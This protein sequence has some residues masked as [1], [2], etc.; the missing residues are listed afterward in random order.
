MDI[1]HVL[2]N[3]LCLIFLKEAHINIL[4]GLFDELNI[5]PHDISFIDKIP[6]IDY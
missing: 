6:T 1:P 4:E 3:L 2:N 5:F